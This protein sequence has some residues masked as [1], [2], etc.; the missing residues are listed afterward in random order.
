M[1]ATVLV[2]KFLSCVVVVVAST[3]LVK[4]NVSHRAELHTNCNQ[5]MFNRL[6]IYDGVM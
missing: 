5:V 3:V 6:R 1:G 4:S 2:A